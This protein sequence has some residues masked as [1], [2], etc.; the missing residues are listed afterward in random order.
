MLDLEMSPVIKFEGIL[1]HW[2]E[3]KKQYQPC[4][5]TGSFQYTFCC[6]I[7]QVPAKE[8]DWMLLNKLEQI[9][10]RREYFCIWQFSQTIFTML[11]NEVQI[12]QL[13]PVLKME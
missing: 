7:F 13:P 5:W 12:F 11:S 2:E 9:K 10:R 6:V 1:E 3:I 4:C 8:L